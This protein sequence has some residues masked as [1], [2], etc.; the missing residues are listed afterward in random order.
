LK[1]IKTCILFLIFITTFILVSRLTLA[2]SFFNPSI[3]QKNTVKSSSSS[4]VL[5]P[6]AYQKLTNQLG[7]QNQNRLST[8]ATKQLGPATPPKPSGGAQPSTTPMNAQRPITSPTQ[9]TQ[10]LPSTSITTQHTSP[11]PITPAPSRVQS[12]YPAATGSPATPAANQNVYTG[13]INNTPSNRGE[14]NKK[15]KPSSGWQIRY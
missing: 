4:R 10:P 1:L 3:S 13:F 9:P 6:E 8:Q 14:T 7:E 5:S 12:A 2:Q 15:P 11:P